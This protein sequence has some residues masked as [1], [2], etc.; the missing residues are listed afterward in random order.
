MG[1]ENRLTAATV[2]VLR[3]QGDEVLV[4]AGDLAGARVVAEQ[5]PLLGAGIRVRDLT[6]EAEAAQV[7]AADP[8]ATESAARAD[9]TAPGTAAGTAA[10]TAPETAADTAGAEPATSAIAA[11]ES[12]TAARAPLPRGPA[13]AL[14]AERRARLIAF[15]EADPTLGEDDRARL[16]ERLSQETVPEGL[17]RRLE[18]RSGI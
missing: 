12:P 8:E 14:T 13:L 11:T 17:V 18:N 1:E 7:A 15:V 10:E 16:R 5:T 3:A 2:E 6:A 9:D 4:A